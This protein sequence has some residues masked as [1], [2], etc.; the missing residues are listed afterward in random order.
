MHIEG[1]YDFEFERELVSHRYSLEETARAYAS[2][3]AYEDGVNKVI[4]RV[5]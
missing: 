4:L 5:G 3:A 2:N 1:R